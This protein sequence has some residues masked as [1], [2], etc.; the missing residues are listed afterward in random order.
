MYEDWDAR[1][2]GNKNEEDWNKI[3][4]EYASENPELSSELKRLIA[5]DLPDRIEDSI[6]SFIEEVQKDLPKMATRVSSQKVLN[7]L[8]PLIPELLG[9]SADLTGSNNTNW[10]GTKEI[11]A[12]D[13][14]GNYINYGVREFGMTG[15]MNGLVLHGGIKAYGGTFLTFLDYARNAVR[16]AALMKIQTILVYSHDSIGVGEDGPTHQPVEHL[17]SLRTTPNLETWRPCDTS[18][19]AISWLAALENTDKPTALIPVS[20]THLTLPTN[21][22]V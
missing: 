22:E 17:T 4:E 5:G 15:I 21:R 19:T 3:L 16:M 11:R 13:F 12:N 8:G 2:T 10:D 18:E 9:G 14:S 6:Y 1:N 20:Y 7:I